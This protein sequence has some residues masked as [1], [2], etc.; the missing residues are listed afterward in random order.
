M[1]RP[2][3]LLA[4]S[5][6]H[7]FLFFIFVFFL[8]LLCFSL[9]L[10]PPPSQHNTHTLSSPDFSSQQQCFSKYKKIQKLL[11]YEGAIESIEHYL[12]HYQEEEVRKRKQSRKNFS[13]TFCMFSSR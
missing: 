9:C 12:I 4:F 8:H 11:S 2:L 13:V 5:F 10:P 7:V 3:S 6:R 1:L